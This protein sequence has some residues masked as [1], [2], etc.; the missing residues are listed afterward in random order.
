MYGCMQAGR[1]SG[2]AQDRT[3]TPPFPQPSSSGRRAWHCRHSCRSHAAQHCFRSLGYVAVVKGG[4]DRLRPRGQAWCTFQIVQNVLMHQQGSVL[5]VLVGAR[6]TVL[7]YCGPLDPGPSSIGLVH[8]GKTL[9]QLSHD[10]Y[11]LLN[12]CTGCPGR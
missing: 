7:L 11:E 4:C 8:M 2:T 10:N 12:A 6:S 5:R 1:Q 9:S 3:L